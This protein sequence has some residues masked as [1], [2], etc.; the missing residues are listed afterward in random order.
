MQQVSYIPGVIISGDVFDGGA[1]RVT[2]GGG[3]ASRGH[4]TIRGRHVR[5]VLGGKP[6][7][8]LIRTLSKP[9]RSAVAAT[10]DRIR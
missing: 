2:I 4:L 6:V 7:S 5:G 8:G 1:A 9:A 10:A 3:N